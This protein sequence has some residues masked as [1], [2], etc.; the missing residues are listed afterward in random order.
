MDEFDALLAEAEMDEFDALLAEAS[1]PTVEP[2]GRYAQTAL[3]LT[4]ALGRTAAGLID[5]GGVAKGIVQFPQQ[6]ILEQVPFQQSALAQ[7]LTFPT[8]AATRRSLERIGERKGLEPE[9]GISRAVEYSMGGVPGLLSGAL[10]EG[11]AGIGQVIGGETGEAI[12]ATTGAIAGLFAPGASAAAMRR[13][14]K[15]FEGLDAKAQRKV[16]DLMNPDELQKLRLAQESGDIVTS[17]DVPKTLAEVTESPY[18]ASI[19][20]ELATGA[21]ASP[22]TAAREARTETLTTAAKEIGTPPTKGEFEYLVNEAVNKGVA[23]KQAAEGALLEKIEGIDAG[24]P[25]AAG[26]EIQQS[27]VARKAAA[28]AE[29]DKKWAQ[30]P[31]T[32][33]INLTDEIDP[34]FDWWDSQDALR[35][36]RASRVG[37]S[38]RELKE[39]ALDPEYPEYI[40][41][42]D[43]FQA[44]R[45]GLND[46]IANT[47]KG[48]ERRL[49]RQL[50]DK[51]DIALGSVDPKELG[52]DLNTKD[53]RALYDAIGATREFSQK[54]REGVVGT[55][56][57]ERLGNLQTKASST[58]R[59]IKRNPACI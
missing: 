24:T 50:K 34:I 47:R 7:A 8:V 29:V 42:Y 40:M 57:R 48:N 59:L 43:R 26:E 46:T 30:V 44:I 4:G 51:M 13:G 56:T 14:A 36:R 27:L 21:K 15:L 33:E 55:L 17:V 19:Q 11:G 41:T 1:T 31:K 37:R 18:L 5:L 2:R 54:Y 22:I 38:I 39:T 53:I 25:R 45:E 58:L 32:Y 28:K 10:M 3:D 6:Y 23:R 16:V 20:A 35:K 12:G 52:Q 49:A 9:S